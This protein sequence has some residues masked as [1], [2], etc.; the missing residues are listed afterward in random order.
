MIVPTWDKILRS[1]LMGRGLFTL[2]EFEKLAV[3]L[4]YEYI[5]WGNKVYTVEEI[6]LN[7][8]WTII[9]NEDTGF[10]VKDGNLFIKST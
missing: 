9:N 8:N 6:D 10:Y 5:T 1:D 3:D 2:K 4:G 7:D